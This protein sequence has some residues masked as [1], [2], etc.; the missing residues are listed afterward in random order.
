[1][2]WLSNISLSNGS[3]TRLYNHAGDITHAF[4]QAGRGIRARVDAATSLGIEMYVV[5]T[6][7]LRYRDFQKQGNSNSA[8][9]EYGHHNTL[10]I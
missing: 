2:M 10:C 7:S 3:D 8:Y 5:L 4:A 6:Y 9:T 1:M